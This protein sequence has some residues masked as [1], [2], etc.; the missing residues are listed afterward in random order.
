MQTTI[1][2]SGFSLAPINALGGDALQLLAQ[3][4]PHN[5]RG[6]KV[7]KGFESPRIS[8]RDARP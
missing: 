4:L 3:G 6:V 8:V 5:N 1:P 2:V 7:N